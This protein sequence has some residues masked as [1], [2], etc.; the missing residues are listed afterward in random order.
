[1]NMNSAFQQVA[2]GLAAMIGGA[3]I[4][5]GPGGTLERY[6]VVGLMGS[7]CVLASL[8]LA[9]KLRSAP[10]A[11]ATEPAPAS[12]PATLAGVGEPPGTR[13]SSA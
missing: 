5:Q 9:R 8:L 13:S 11:P 1:M 4:V 10:V 7:A 6:V 2:S 3:I 12:A